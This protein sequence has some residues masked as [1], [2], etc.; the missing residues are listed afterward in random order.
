M[1]RY[2]TRHVSAPWI[3]CDVC[4]K[5]ADAQVR[6]EPDGSGGHGRKG[7]RALGYY[8]QKHA[9]EKLSALRKKQRRTS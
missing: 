6:V 9:E 2:I 7:A 3:K 8:C 5:P 4:K 1:S